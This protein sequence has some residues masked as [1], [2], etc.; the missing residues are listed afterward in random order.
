MS[1]PEYRNFD[2]YKIWESLG[3]VV[4]LLLQEKEQL[5]KGFNKS[6]YKNVEKFYSDFDMFY[7]QYNNLSIELK[8]KLNE[9]SD[10]PTNEKERK[11]FDLEKKVSLKILISGGGLENIIDN[12]V[13]DMGDSNSNGLKGYLS[14]FRKEM[15]DQYMQFINTYDQTNKGFGI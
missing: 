5:E 8:D 15:V 13:S 12:M 6:N 9:W 1:E 10:L 2:P 7:N 11:E 4:D 3:D 14:N